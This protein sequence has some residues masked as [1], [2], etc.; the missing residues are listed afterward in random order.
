[1]ALWDAVVH[2]NRCCVCK[3]RADVHEMLQRC[4][5]LW[6]SGLLYDW[7]SVSTRNP[8]GLIAQFKRL[9]GIPRSITGPMQQQ[10]RSCLHQGQQTLAT[11][12]HLS[13]PAPAAM[14][15]LCM[16]IHMHCGMHIAP[17]ATTE[18]TCS[19][20]ATST[21]ARQQLTWYPHPC[22]RNERQQMAVPAQIKGAEGL[23]KTKKPL[24]A[25]SQG[26][27]KNRHASFWPHSCRHHCNPRVPRM[28]P[29]RGCS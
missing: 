2:R 19:H 17:Q 4:G 15:R 5:W 27:P 9:S 26:C 10:G 3:A 7:Q 29:S 13:P 6:L 8:S 12:R 22:Y 20:N 25:I 11:H 24:N 18:T 28:L 23:S 14:S 21:Q 16:H 1:M